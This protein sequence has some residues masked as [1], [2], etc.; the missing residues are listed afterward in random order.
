[1]KSKTIKTDFNRIVPLI[2]KLEVVTQ[3]HILHIARFVLP[4][5]A[6]ISFVKRFWQF[7]W[8]NLKAEHANFLPLSIMSSFVVTFI[9]KNIYKVKC[10]SNHKLEG[11]WKI[12]CIKTLCMWYRHTST[13]QVTHFIVK[14]HVFNTIVNDE[15]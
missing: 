13:H 1:M 7:F 12:R 3:V 8:G 15:F 10:P 9:N 2:F 5:I 14:F 4:K 11:F 6:S